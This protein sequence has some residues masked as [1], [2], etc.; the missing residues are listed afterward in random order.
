M[1]QTLVLINAND[2]I[3]LEEDGTTE[4]GLEPIKE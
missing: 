1:P 3:L 2:N 4:L